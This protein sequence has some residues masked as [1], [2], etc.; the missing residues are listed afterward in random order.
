MKSYL[1][2]IPISAKIHRKYT[3]MTR[4]CIVL[5]VLLI[6]VIFSMANMFL[7]SQKNQ[8][9][10]SDGAW[11]VVFSNPSEEQITRINARPEVKVGSRYAV[12][13]YRLDLDYK[14]QGTQTVLCGFDETLFTLFPGI[15]LIEGIFPHK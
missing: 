14:I 12:T 15:H 11:H 9:I 8:A 10:Q 4:L 2:L 13:N 7:E 1:E 3:R 5:S 6:A